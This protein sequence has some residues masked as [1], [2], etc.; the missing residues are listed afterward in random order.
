MLTD[1]QTGNKTVKITWYT[2]NLNSTNAG[3]KLTLWEE[4]E[5]TAATRLDRQP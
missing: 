2:D 1:I 5:N 4:K 3:F